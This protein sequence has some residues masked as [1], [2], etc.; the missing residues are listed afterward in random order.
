MFF[1]KGRDTESRSIQDAPVTYRWG[2]ILEG[3]SDFLLRQHFGPGIHHD[4]IW[5]RSAHYRG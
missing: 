2:G 3:G 1:R 5:N 4:L